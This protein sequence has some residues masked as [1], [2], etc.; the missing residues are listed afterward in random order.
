M[1]HFPQKSESSSYNLSNYSWRAQVPMSIQK[2]HWFQRLINFLNSS[3]RKIVLNSVLHYRYSIMETDSKTWTILSVV[4]PRF[5]CSWCIFEYNS[6]AKHC[7][8][9]AILHLHTYV[10]L[11]KGK[12]LSQSEKE[13]FYL[14]AASFSENQKISSRYTLHEVKT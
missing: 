11:L 2:S 3:K 14:V 10:A 12:A 6:R 5:W 1:C 8:H 7:L 9:S 13:I 4:S